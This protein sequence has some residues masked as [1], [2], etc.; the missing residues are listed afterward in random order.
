MGGAEIRGGLLRL[1][2]SDHISRG[3]VP[4][5]DCSR[6]SP[7]L[8]QYLTLGEDSSPNIEDHILV[9]LFIFCSLLLTKVLAAVM[10]VGSL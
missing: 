9:W 10:K 2:T 6:F 3:A 5:N 1:L 7:Y 8:F 4:E